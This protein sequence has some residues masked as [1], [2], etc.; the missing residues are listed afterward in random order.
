MPKKYFLSFGNKNFKNS[1]ERIKNEAIHF[2]E[3]DE[4]ICY[5]DQSLKLFHDFWNKHKEWIEKNQ[6]GYGYWIWKPFL[7]YEE[8]KKMEDNDYLV[9]VDAGCTL[10]VQAKKR[11]FDYIDMADKNTGNICCF[12]LHVHRERLW[13]KND[14]FEHF[15]IK[16]YEFKN[17]MQIISGIIIIKKTKISEEIIKLWRD[18]MDSNYHLIDDSTSNTKNDLEFIEN[19]HDQSILS[20]I[21]KIYNVPSIGDETWAENL[22]DPEFLKKSPIIASRIKI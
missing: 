5:D 20:V 13:T 18:T 17:T 21:L 19:R 11:F 1:I 3:F 10:N 12:N 16:D 8:L 7:I 9:W 15:N 6:R 2:G 4:V 14:I 22:N